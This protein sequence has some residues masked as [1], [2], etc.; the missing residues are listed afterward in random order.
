MPKLDSPVKRWPGSVT[1]PEYLTWPQ[2]EAWQQAAS[3]ATEATALA[4]RQLA[5]VRGI[6]AIVSTWELTGLPSSMTPE[7]FPATPPK[8]SVALMGWLIRSISDLLNEV[9]EIPNE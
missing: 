2:L 4:A 9:D 8:S 7:S 6:C 1:L 5:W 3:E